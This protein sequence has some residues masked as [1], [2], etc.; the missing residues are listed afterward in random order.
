M[1]SLNVSAV[2]KY[3][4]CAPFRGVY[5]L[6]LANYCFYFIHKHICRSGVILCE[7]TLEYPADPYP[8]VPWCDSLRVLSCGIFLIYISLMRVFATSAA[9]GGCAPAPRY[10]PPV[11]C[12]DRVFWT[13][14]ALGLLHE[15]N[16]VECGIWY[17]K[18]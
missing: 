18:A 3:R 2:H 12:S 7:N 13:A 11:S 6:F 17:N 1:T 5:T 14:P 8:D 10:L 15:I 9:P 16:G 4:V